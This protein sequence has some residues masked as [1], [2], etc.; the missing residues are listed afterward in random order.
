[1]L[2]ISSAGLYQE[3]KYIKKILRKKND[4]KGTI[5]KVIKKTRWHQNIHVWEK[6]FNEI[7]ELEN[8]MIFSYVVRSTSWPRLS[9]HL[10]ILH[11]L[12]NSAKS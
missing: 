1:M 10:K 5:S 4:A 7:D 3:F 8:E 6:F 11:K 12:V 9:I 2:D